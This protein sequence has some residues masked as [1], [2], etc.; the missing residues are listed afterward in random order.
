MHASSA[1]PNM[2]PFIPPW[3]QVACVVP[4]EVFS[5]STD[6]EFIPATYSLDPSALT[7]R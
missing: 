1:I 6:G 2:P 3:V 7:A 4:S 5:T